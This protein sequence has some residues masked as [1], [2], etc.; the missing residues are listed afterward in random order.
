MVL[1]A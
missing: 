1:M